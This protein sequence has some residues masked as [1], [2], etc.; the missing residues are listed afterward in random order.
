MNYNGSKLPFNFRTARPGSTQS[1]KFYTGRLRPEVQ[2]LTLLYTIFG[3][4]G[5][6]LVYVLLTNQGNPLT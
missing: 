6:P 2:I 1:T 5:S 3:R 4:K